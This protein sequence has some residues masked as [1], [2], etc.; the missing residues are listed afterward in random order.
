LVHGA[1]VVA[2]FLPKDTTP[3]DWLNLLAGMWVPVLG[4]LISYGTYF[5]QHYLRNG[6]YRYASIDKL[7]LEPYI[8][9]IPMHVGLIAAGFFI[10]ML[11]SPIWVVLF[12][13]ALKTGG[14]AFAYHR[15]MQK[16]RSPA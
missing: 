7:M 11:G 14:E 9:I 16:R 5:V 4:M 2:L 15:S 12:L 1:F 6:A 3:G 8:R 10:V 13:V